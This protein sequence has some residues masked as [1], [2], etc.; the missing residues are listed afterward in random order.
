MAARL[1]PKC[2]LKYPDEAEWKLCIVCGKKTQ[3]AGKAKL[4]KNWRYAIYNA[5]CEYR[6]AQG[7]TA[8][9]DEK[10]KRRMAEAEAQFEELKRLEAALKNTKETA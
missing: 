6:D 2:E 4:D 8:E 1:C 3:V 9:P 7:I 10:T 5:L